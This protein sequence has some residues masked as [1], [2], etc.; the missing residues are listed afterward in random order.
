MSDVTTP[1]LLNPAQSWATSEIAI[2]LGSGSVAS[3]V[4]P[5]ANL[6]IFYPRVLP[7]PFLLS[8]F[9]WV[10]G[11]AV[12][13]NID[14]GVFTPGGARI[15]S[16]GSTAQ[17]GTSAIQSVNLGT[18][19]LLPPGSYLFGL[20][21]SSASAQFIRRAPVVGLLVTYGFAQQSS[22]LPLPDPA[23]FTS[24]TNSYLPYFGITNRSI[25]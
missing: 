19:I 16:T 2:Q 22:A 5:S 15:A 8:R 11:S 14:C 17:S 20:A 24:I 7:V 9:W 13:G 21:A 4:W 10:N 23:T 25:I 12:A 1:A 18:P 3:A 6:A